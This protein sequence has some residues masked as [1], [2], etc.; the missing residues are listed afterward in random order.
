MENAALQAYL[1][2]HALL[3]DMEAGYIEALA[4]CASEAEFHE[5]ELVFRQGTAADWDVRTII[6][7]DKGHLIIESAAD[8]PGLASVDQFMGKLIAPDGTSRDLTIAQTA[9]S[10]FEARFMCM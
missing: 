6:D 1:K 5:G 4:E 3:R 10:R 2:D 9:P 8:T 7:G